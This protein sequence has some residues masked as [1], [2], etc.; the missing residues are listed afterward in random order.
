MKTGAPAQVG[1]PGPKR[2]NVTVPVGGGTGAGAP[3]TVAVSLI[4]D[5]MLPDAAVVVMVT[6]PGTTIDSWPG[7]PQAPVI[8]A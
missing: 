7:A 3:V 4:G 5:P 2:V 1:S 8:G 6:G